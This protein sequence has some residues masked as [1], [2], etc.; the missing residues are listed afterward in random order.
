MA[1]RNY[2]VQTNDSLSII[3]RDEVGDIARWYEIA[4]INSITAPYTIFPGQVLLL[5]DDEPLVFDI[6]EYAKN[7]QA[8]PVQKASIVFNPATVALI[9]AGAALI[10]FWDDIF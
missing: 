1:K 7:G 6:T 5:P 8:A 3:A 4:Y 9:V 2:I 10:Y